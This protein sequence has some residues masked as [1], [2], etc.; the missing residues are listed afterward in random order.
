[1]LW[2]PRQEVD[3]R[4]PLPQV[5]IILHQL[6]VSVNKYCS[7]HQRAIQKTYS[8]ISTPAVFSGIH[9]TN[10]PPHLTVVLPEWILTVSKEEHIEKGAS[11][12]KA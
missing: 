5:S 10:H 11:K 7:I 8:P 1:M 4:V 3:G 12:K 2:L 9:E 6:I